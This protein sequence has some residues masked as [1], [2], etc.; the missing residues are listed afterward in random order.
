MSQSTP[1][2]AILALTLSLAAGA[3]FGG[4]PEGWPQWGG[5]NQD[6]QAPSDGLA[7]SWPE[8]GPPE[9]WKRDLGDGYSTILYEDGR[10]YTMYRSDDEEAVVCLDAATGATVWETRYD[11]SPWEQQTPQFG[12]GPRS[13][14]LLSGDRLYAIGVAG[15]L[16]SLD[17]KDGKILWTREL[18]SEEDLAGNHLTFGYSSSPIA[19]GDTVIALVGGDKASVAAFHQ[20]DGSLA[21]KS[22]SQPF[23]NS[24]STPQILAVDG[25][26]QLVTFMAKELIALDPKSGELLW[27]YPHENQFE[28]NINMPTLVDGRYLFLSSPHAGARG[29]KLTVGDGGKT[30]VEE[31]WSTRK[32][33]FYHVTTVR[34]GDWVY[35]TTG[36]RAP[37]F[38][39]AINVKTGDIAWRERGFA[40]AN[41]V[42][43]DG[44]L[45][46]LDEDGKLYLATATPEALTV[47][48]QV[49]LLDGVAWSAPTIVGKTLYVR[50]KSH[51]MALHLGGP[52]A[53][54]MKQGA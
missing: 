15:R 8:G 29:L 20:K 24:Y 47:H 9:I 18:W 54:P 42:G 36:L 19:Y 43:A 53:G 13:T 33:Q 17:K 38:M 35:G 14:P 2:I 37:A 5:P 39:A 30:T 6:F 1:R 51:I 52:A 26:E 34:Q 32:I 23:Q 25:Q 49:E 4:P 16:Q 45:I 3:A 50:D 10:L 28:Q 7:D 41:T 48:S 27:S 44:R 40:K 31:I 46:V 11:H 21:W 22:A 12:N